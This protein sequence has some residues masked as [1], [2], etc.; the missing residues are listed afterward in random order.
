MG[1]GDGIVVIEEMEKDLERG[2][3]I[4]EEVIGYGMQGDELNI[5]EKKE[6]G[7]GEKR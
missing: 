6:R 5:K 4:Y 2:E 7:E 3:K 1:E